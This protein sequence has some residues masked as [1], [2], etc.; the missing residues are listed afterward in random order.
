[1]D[2]K[3]LNEYRK[4]RIHFIGIGGC[5]MSGLAMVLKNLGFEVTGSDMRESAFTERLEKENIPF[6]IGHFEKNISG[7]GLIVYSAAI[8]P[9]NIELKTAAAQN[10][11]V[12]TRAELLGKLSAEYK[13]V[14]CISGCH[15]KTTITSMTALILAAAGIDAT[16]HVGGMVDFLGGGVRLGN[17]DI[18]VTEACEYM[19]SFLKLI[20]THI[21]VHNIDDDH[22]DYFRDI[23]H[24]YSSF[25]RFVSMLPA[26]G[27]LFC[28]GDE[29][30]SLRLYNESDVKK[31]TYGLNGNN[32]FTA[33]NIEF[34]EKGNTSFDF[35]AEGVLKGRIVLNIPGKHNILNALAAMALTTTVFRADI[36]SCAAALLKYRLAERRFE[37]LGERNGVRI[38]HDY[39]HHPSEI[40]ACLKAAVTIPHNKLWALFQCNSFTR[41]KTLKDKYA[42]AF[43]AADEVIVP[44]IYPGRDI[45]KGEIHAKDLVDA[46]SKS[47]RSVYIPTF[48]QIRDYLDMHAQPGDMVIT[49]GSGDVNKQSYKL[50]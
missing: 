35:Y 16:V 7:A 8:K 11:P 40:D 38:I 22:L 12:I 41:A 44:D 30:L 14:A 17:S 46:I 50:L 13:T 3:G 2:I 9:E 15:G 26:T 5:S 47:S 21:V 6:T 42:L 24:I 23:E 27:A 34:D 48:G 39:A 10:I 4:K 1:M 28:C 32:Y 37:F 49:L 25:Q 45:D 19:E 43:S 29:P 36:K 31:Y 18:L 20:P 33:K